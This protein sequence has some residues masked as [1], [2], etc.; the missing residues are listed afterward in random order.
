MCLL[1]VGCCSLSDKEYKDVMNLDLEIGDH[2]DF[3]LNYGNLRIGPR[4]L[5]WGSTEENG[6]IFVIDP[7]KLTHVAWDEGRRS[8]LANT[9]Y[10]GDITDFIV[11]EENG[12]WIILA[13]QAYPAEIYKI[14]VPIEGRNL[15]DPNK[16]S[17]KL[18]YSNSEWD[19]VMSIEVGTSATGERLILAGS[20]KNA[21]LILSTDSGESW[22]SINYFSSNQQTANLRNQ[23]SRASSISEI[24]Y[25]NGDWYIFLY[26]AFLLEGEKPWE[27]GYR[28]FINGL[29]ISRDDGKTWEIANIPG[30]VSFS[31]E[32]TQLILEDRRINN[33]PEGF[34]GLVGEVGQSL[35]I[36]D[37]DIL[38]FSTGIDN[39]PQKPFGGR[40]LKS[41][42]RGRTWYEVFSF[43]EFADIQL[44][45]DN[46]GNLIAGSASKAIFG[47]DVVGTGEI[48]ISMDG[49]ESFKYVT[50]IVE[51]NLESRLR[52]SVI[53]VGVSSIV[54]TKNGLFIATVDEGF[55]GELF[56]L[57]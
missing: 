11:F 51:N 23:L 4:G 5:I 1:I 17:R 6:F 53:V 33:L 54:S 35:V 49:G 57:K 39:D 37:R 7:K 13:C 52:D 43:T 18:V 40:V 26:H 15:P 48:W 38:Y 25:I 42:D 30:N 10:A 46:W 2:D 14:T 29:L 44:A 24:D 56:L 31:S 45:V 12:N 47:P 21:E 22:K 20:Y 27:S 50:T 55:K 8:A 9:D 3:E 19:R 34:Y 16:I 28:H 32:I 41:V 36:M